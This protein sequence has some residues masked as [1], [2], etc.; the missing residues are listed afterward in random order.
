MKL[1]E[2]RSFVLLLYR[3]FFYFILFSSVTKLAGGIGNRDIV[4]IRNSSD[5]ILQLSLFPI[6]PLATV[7]PGNQREGFKKGGLFRWRMARNTCKF[8]HQTH[9]CAT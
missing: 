4:M 7:H 2:L 8:P 1:L 5:R 3:S 9:S 6:L